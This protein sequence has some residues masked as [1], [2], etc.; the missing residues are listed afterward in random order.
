MTV[1]GL[2]GL[3]AALCQYLAGE[4]HGIELLDGLPAERAELPRD[5]TAIAVELD[6]IKSLA[7]GLDKYIGGAEESGAGSAMEIKLRLEIYDVRSPESCRAAFADMAEALLLSGCPMQ[8]LAVECSAAEFDRRAGAFRL[9]AT[10]LLRALLT[11]ADDS[12]HI[13]DFEIRSESL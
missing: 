3:R 13:T 4:L 9:A 5:K 1:N 11:R 7:L 10:G 8:V 2:A 6:G 12:S